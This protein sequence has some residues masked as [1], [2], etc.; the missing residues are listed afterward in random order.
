MNRK[1]KLAFAACFAAGALFLGSL[2]VGPRAVAQ[3]VFAALGI[4]NTWTAVQTFNA[5]SSF[6][7]NIT[8]LATGQLLGSATFPWDG[9][10]RNLN[11]AL[12][13]LPTTNQIVVG[14]SPNQTTLNFPA[15]AGNIT[16][17]FPSTGGSVAAAIS[18]QKSGTNNGTN[19]TSPSTSFVD[20]D[21]TNL[22]YTVTIPT[23]WRLQ[24]IATTSVFVQTALVNV[25]M[26]IFDSVP[27]TQIV[28]HN[29]ILPPGLSS[30]VPATLNWQIS[31]D[32][33]SHT[34]KLQF[35]TSNTADSVGIRNGNGDVPVMDFLLLSN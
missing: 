27:N 1:L 12:S 11:Q 32:G 29:F 20:V 17:S 35:A 26:A 2:L 8:P 30:D 15:P 14:T 28:R 10:I 18:T 16:L 19:Y 9:Y 22:A 31:G 7:G 6:G 23:G 13:I 4:A 5:N 34:I 33:L 3:N 21:V 24:I 25:G